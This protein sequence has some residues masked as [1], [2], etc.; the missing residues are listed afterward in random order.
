MGAN[1]AQE[2][3]LSNTATLTSLDLADITGS[4]HDNVQRS[5]KRSVQNG[6]VTM[7]PS[8]KGP[9]GK[10]GREIKYYVFRGDKGK[11][12]SDKGKRDSFRVLERMTASQA[13][14]I[15][16]RWRELEAEASVA[17]TST[18]GALTTRVVSPVQQVTPAGGHVTP[19]GQ[20][21]TAQGTPVAELRSGVTRITSPGAEEL[22]MSSLEIAQLTGKRHDHVMRDISNVLG[23]L[24][25]EDGPNFGGTY[26]DS[27][28]REKPCY[29]LPRRETD[30][31]LTGY[32]IPM[33]AKVIDRWHEL[34]AQV[35][36][37]A[38]VDLGDAS[39][40]RGLLLGYT[41]QVMQLEH[42]VGIQA[43]KI[44]EDAPKAKFHD[45]VADSEGL[46]PVAEVAK[47]LGT[48]EKRLFKY[49]RKHKILISDGATRNTPYQPFLDSGRMDVKCTDYIVPETG[50]VKIHSQPLFTGKGL[51]W[52]QQF[53]EEHGRVG[54]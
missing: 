47:I 21:I 50:K 46:K 15:A 42:K 33:R 11:R 43:A 5:I 18:V 41:E 14:A 45:K 48:G 52:I 29:Q 28:Q 17:L 16:A 10:N 31:L 27:L 7:P 37:P 4:R 6:K 23:E 30:I 8:E 13:D 12:D 49:L 38:P 26:I 25:G 54:L 34:E 40:L 22:T 9:V 2:S 36:K 35:A 3:N 20:P 39:A 51:I 19:V 53:I 24:H 32:S 44:A 1:F